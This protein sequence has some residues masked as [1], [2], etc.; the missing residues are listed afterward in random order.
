[1]ILVGVRDA[2][3]D[4]EWEGKVEMAHETLKRSATGLL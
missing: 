2:F 3:R 1:M 4:A